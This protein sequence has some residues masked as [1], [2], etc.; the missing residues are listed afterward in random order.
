MHPTLVHARTPRRNHHRRAA[1]GMHNLEF[2]G[3]RAPVHG[4]FAEVSSCPSLLI[5]F[6]H[7]QGFFFSSRLVYFSLS[8]KE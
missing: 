5:C 2:E 8:S 7:E 6:C 1:Q 3:P 4:S